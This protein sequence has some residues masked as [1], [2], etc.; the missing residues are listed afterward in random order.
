MKKIDFIIGSLI[1]GGAEH[2]ISIL[3]NHYC[4]MGFEVNVV[5]LLHGAIEYDLN[6]KINIVRLYGNTKSRFLRIT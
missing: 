3:A 2:V 6:P 1:R 4:E 5:L